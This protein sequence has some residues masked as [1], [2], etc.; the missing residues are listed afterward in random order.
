MAYTGFSRSTLPV[1][2]WQPVAA[3]RPAMTPDWVNIASWFVNA[4]V[5]VGDN[6]FF[7]VCFDVNV[8]VGVVGEVRIVSSAGEVSGTAKFWRYVER[9][10]LWMY[11]PAV[12]IDKIIWL[13]ARRSS[14]SAVYSGG[15]HVPQ[16]AAMQISTVPP[17][18]YAAPQYPVGYDPNG[19]PDPPP[20]V[21]SVTFSVP[22]PASVGLPVGTVP[23][24]DN[25][26]INF[27][28]FAL[29]NIGGAFAIDNTGLITVANPDAVAQHAQFTLR[30]AA[31]D[32][33]G[34]VGQGTV[35]INV[36][37]HQYPPSY[38]TTD[39]YGSSTAQQRT[40]GLPTSSNG[41][42]SA[43]IA[44][45]PIVASEVSATIQVITVP[46]T[47]NVE[48][49]ALQVDYIDDFG[50][51]IA[52]VHTG[53]QYHPSYPGN[54]AVNYGGYVSATGVEVVGPTSPALTSTTG[55]LN[56]YDYLWVVGRSYRFRCYSPISGIWR[57]TVT[58]L[59]TSTTTILRDL[60]IPAATKVRGAILFAEDFVD[61]SIG[62]EAR[63]SNV[64]F[65]G[66][67][68]AQSPNVGV[69]NYQ[70]Y[71][72]GGCTNTNVTVQ[73]GVLSVVTGTART[74]ADGTTFPLL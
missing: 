46:T 11:E 29:G 9:T 62:T 28:G 40:S 69:V 54:R 38:T 21:S 56:T 8:D 16:A 31:T 70:D 58:D 64:T 27:V 33:P 67:A 73:S 30:V 24:T 5:I 43:I 42:S 59:T 35:T 13:Q 65:G 39:P 41:A 61:C 50:T 51:S 52:V 22:S 18:F 44:V 66:G 55:S 26:V 6:W 37:S 10:V 45:P 23:I 48:F 12:G 1:R 74:N 17:S 47:A 4:P 36:V 63:F 57:A 7:G 20:I 15:V 3:D 14:S 34:N 60:P 25:G 71:V 32:L 19:N 49:W 2:E 68:T 53:L 72:D